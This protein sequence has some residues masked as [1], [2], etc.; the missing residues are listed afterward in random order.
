MT[1]VTATGHV[2]ARAL[3][4]DAPAEG[5][6]VRDDT[7][8]FAGRVVRVFGPVARPYLSIRPRRPLRGAEA[9]RLLGT[10][11]RV[12]EGTNGAG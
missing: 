9:A 3:G 8:R 11:L 2:T 10:S 5:S 4:P 7:G 12:A 6:V 1:A